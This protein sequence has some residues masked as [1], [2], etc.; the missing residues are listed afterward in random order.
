M[1]AQW[2][3]ADGD[4]L[5]ICLVYIVV[6][7]G[8]AEGLR[9]WRGYGAGFTRKVIHI[10]V[11]MMIWLVPWVFEEPWVFMGCAVLFGFINLADWY[12]G[13]LPAMASEDEGN[14][15]TVY[16]PWV[17]AVAV[18]WL[19]EWPPLLVAAIMPL[20]WGDGL[21]SVVGRRWGRHAYYVRGH[22]RTWEGSGA[23]LVG[24]V[25]AV[26]AALWL[27]GGES[28]VVGVEVLLVAVVV[29]VVTAVTEAISL[30]GFDNITVTL[31]AI[32]ILTWWP[33]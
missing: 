30:G 23:F 13:L 15:G 25:L 28:V 5:L 19:W 16:F 9:R 18:W 7:I 10:G 21:A 26:G 32:G 3:R 14:L 17:A 6:V 8:V 11:G 22:K 29:G 31:V 33:F 12:W 20:T 2:L 27:V 4:G 24:T 1:I